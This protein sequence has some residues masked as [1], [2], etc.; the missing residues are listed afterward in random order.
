MPMADAPASPAY[1][2]LNLAPNQAPSGLSAE[3]IAPIE[4]IDAF[5]D[6]FFTY[7]HPLTPFPHEPSFR[8]AWAQRKDR[9]DRFFLA[10]LAGM[11]GG[12]VSMFPRRPQKHLKA[13]GKEALF[14]NTS[15]LV[16]VCRAVCLEARGAGYLER[17][18]LYVYDAATS[19]FLL[20][21]STF[22]YRWQAADMYI[23]ECFTII[24]ASGFYTARPSYPPADYGARAALSTEQ[25][26]NFIDEE[27]GRRVFWTIYVT[28]R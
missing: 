2:A 22:M 25:D 21:M 18:G 1:P 7:A 10:L 24:R 9:Q 3:S 13:L 17:E 26:M 23:G 5:I 4:L 14:P 20:I 15:A 6:D 11:I 16:D 27:V 28:V 19:Y 8:A 12:L